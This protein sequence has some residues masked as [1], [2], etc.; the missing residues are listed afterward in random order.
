MLQDDFNG[1]MVVVKAAQSVA[2]GVAARD[3][4]P[5]DFTGDERSDIR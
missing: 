4:Q 3:G 2:P 1:R 5:G